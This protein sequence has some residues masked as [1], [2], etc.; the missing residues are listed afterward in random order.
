MAF[1]VSISGKPGGGGSNVAFCVSDKGQK[2][3]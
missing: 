2:D 3:R 1:P